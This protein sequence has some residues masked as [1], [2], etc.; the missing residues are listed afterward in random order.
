MGRIAKLATAS[1]IRIV[2]F[3]F[4]R[5]LECVIRSFLPDQSSSVGLYLSTSDARLTR[6]LAGSNKLSKLLI[7]K[8]LEISIF[9]CRMMSH[10]TKSSSGLTKDDGKLTSLV[11]A[12]VSEDF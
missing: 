2:F 1:V 7:T 6:L 4:V 12:H 8:G 5:L 11:F 3:T 10:P 9:G